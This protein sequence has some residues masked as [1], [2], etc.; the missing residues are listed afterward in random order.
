LDVLKRWRGEGERK[1]L[2][3]ANT[4]GSRIQSVKTAWLAL[5]KAAGIKDFRWHD[6]R[7]TF[8]SKL[9]QRGVDLAVVRELLGHGDFALTVRYAHLE[10]KQSAQAVAML[11]A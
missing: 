9:V 1:G 4:D 3:F 6:L 8:A 2:V 10:P 7:H 5:L 11:M